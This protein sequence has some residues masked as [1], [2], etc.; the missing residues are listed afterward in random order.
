MSRFKLS[1]H[2][3]DNVSGSQI[4]QS[5]EY[6]PCKRGV[7]GSSPGLYIFLTLWH[8]APNRGTC[9]QTWLVWEDTLQWIFTSKIRGR[10]RS[11]CTFFSPCD[12]TPIFLTVFQSWTKYHYQHYSHKYILPNSPQ[13]DLSLPT[14]LIK[15][16]IC[17]K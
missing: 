12:I 5:V 16:S 9:M 3:E 10:I 15:P 1:H 11:D 8:L 6:S 17:L 4:V 7:L 14:R 13:E 2:W